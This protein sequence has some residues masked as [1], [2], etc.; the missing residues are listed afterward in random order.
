MLCAS[1]DARSMQDYAAAHLWRRP[2]GAPDTRMLTQPVWSTWAQYKADINASVVLDFGREIVARGFTASQLEIDDNWET[3]YGEAAFDPDR[4]PDPARLVEDLKA[5]GFRVTLWVHPFI[6]MNCAA[7]YAEA[8]SP[9]RMYLVRDPRGKFVSAGGQ[10]GDWEG[11]AHLPGLVWWWQ[12]VMAG[13]FCHANLFYFKRDTV[14][15]FFYLNSL[16]V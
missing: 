5:L 1:S 6:N 8:A 12:G 3:C 4:F 16:T 2:A 9:P 7:S 14:V 11:V 10:F 13:N 15:F